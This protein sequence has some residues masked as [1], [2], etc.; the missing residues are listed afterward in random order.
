V[1]KISIVIAPLSILG[2]LHF[3]V[4]SCKKANDKLFWVTQNSGQTSD[5]LF[6]A[7]STNIPTLKDDSLKLFFS[8][9]EIK[10]ISENSISCK[11]FG[12]IYDGPKFKAYVLLM[13]MKTVGRDYVFVIQTCD[14]NFKK[15][16][17][18]ELAY[19]DEM[20][21]QY[22]FGS[23][24]KDLIIERACNFQKESETMQ[25]ASDGKIIV[26]PLHKP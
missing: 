7:E 3:S 23:I 20:E 12:K 15:I 11:N 16:D 22:C 26:L 13:I 9:E 10:A 25:I 19:W 24:N 6:L 4:A 18:F 21:K 1:K 2:I 17:K 5:F 8:Q 14:S